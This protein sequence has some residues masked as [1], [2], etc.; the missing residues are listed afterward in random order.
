MLTEIFLALTFVRVYN[1]RGF[2]SSVL[3][4]R[5]RDSKCK[6]IRS[7]NLI[8]KPAP[9]PVCESQTIARTLR[10]A[11]EPTCCLPSYGSGSLDSL[12]VGVFCESRELFSGDVLRPGA[13][14]HGIFEAR[15]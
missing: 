10:L 8:F 9:S 1:C 3:I 13:S 7:E 6:K 2:K 12:E 4:S 11:Y 5:P 14:R 15:M